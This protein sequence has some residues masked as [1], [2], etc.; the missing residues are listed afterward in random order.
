MNLLHTIEQS[1]LETFKCHAIENGVLVNT[2]CLYPSNA[3]V[4]VIVY[5]CS[6]EFYVTDAGGWRKE[7]EDAGAYDKLR[8]R[9]VQ[10]A[11]SKQGLHL[12]Q[13]GA[14]RSPS[15]N[16]KDIPAAIAVVANISKEISHTIYSSW[17]FPRKKFKERVRE[18][19]KQQFSE[20]DVSEKKISGASNKVHT[21]EN[22]ISLHSG[23]QIIIDPVIRDAASIN[24][25]IVANMDVHSKSYDHV[26]QAIIYD[27]EERWSSDE[28]NLL[29]LP[30][31][32]V[33]A[34]SRNATRLRE[35]VGI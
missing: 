19:I 34:F 28:L 25:R 15:I 10:T 27:D 1:L 21:F 18:V 17:K 20:S 29:G 2:H 6:S 3:V 35:F 33:L 30:S 26:R 12:D 32:P 7:L 11:A 8:D 5:G 14:I 23:L 9:H 13:A 22:V 24:S 16:A 31:V 4:K